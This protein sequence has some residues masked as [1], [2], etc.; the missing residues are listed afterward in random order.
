MAGWFRN[1]FPKKPA[2]PAPIAAPRPRPAAFESLFGVALAAPATA[3]ATPALALAVDG[4]AAKETIMIAG[5]CCADSLVQMF[6]TDDR[7]RAQYRFI[8]L[9]SVEDRRLTDAQKAEI[10]AARRIVIQ[11]VGS[12]E[13]KAIEAC[14]PDQ[15]EI[16]RFP[17]LNLRALWPWNWR[18]LP[19]AQ[20]DTLLPQARFVYC[21][22]ALE[23]LRKTI[24]DKTELLAAYRQTQPT[25]M[26]TFLKLHAF[27]QHQLLEYDEIYGMTI[28]ARILAA[29]P[30][31]QIFYNPSHPHMIIY[32]W[33][34]EHIWA[35][36]NLPGTC[37]VFAGGDTW[38][39]HSLP[40]HPAVAAHFGLAWANDATV[41]TNKVAGAV[42]WE[43]YTRAY[44]AAMD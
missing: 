3:L 39:Q 35:K 32:Q 4:I 12:I 7:L 10:C 25:M 37:P 6:Q 33:L 15:C 1:L 22:T 19:P 44:I 9:G 27:D 13:A 26:Q 28:G 14:V 5:N 24:S 20:G 38:R 30:E 34:G 43:D 36:L 42:T 31:R 11:D 29:V 2:T 40:V 23:S 21:D 16:I 8:R 17:Q 41:Y 18:M